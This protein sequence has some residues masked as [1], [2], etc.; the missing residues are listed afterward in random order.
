[1]CKV[2]VLIVYETPNL[3][4]TSRLI[5]YVGDISCQIGSLVGRYK[6]QLY[7]KFLLF[8]TRCKSAGAGGSPTDFGS[9]GEY[10]SWG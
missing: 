9:A 1:M 8:T 7:L 5:G 2:P 4:G 3:R 10:Y 6:V